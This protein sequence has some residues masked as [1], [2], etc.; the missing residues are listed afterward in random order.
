MAWAFRKSGLQMG[1]RASAFYADR[2]SEEAGVTVRKAATVR[3]AMSAGFVRMLLMIALPVVVAVVALLLGADIGTGRWV[4]AG[5]FLIVVSALVTLGWFGY[6]WWRRRRV[7]GKSAGG[8][9][10][11]EM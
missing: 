6:R 1:R 4:S 8:R 9:P 5:T 11:L 7:L 3:I 10:S 2:K